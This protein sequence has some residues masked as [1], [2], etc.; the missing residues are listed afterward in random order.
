MLYTNLCIC[1]TS[2]RSFVLSYSIT[3]QSVFLLFLSLCCTAITLFIS[4]LASH[5]SSSPPISS[6]IFIASL[7]MHE[8]VELQINHSLSSLATHSHSLIDA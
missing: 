3:P 5:S 6:T 1:F 7:L 4:T 8:L 2:L